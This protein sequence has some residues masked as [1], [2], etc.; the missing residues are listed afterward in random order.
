MSNTT[1]D[2]KF[3]GD[4]VEGS[5]RSA[6]VVA[7]IV[8]NLTPIRSVVD[9]GCGHATW[10]RAF[11]ELGVDDVLGLDGDYVDRSKIL[12]DPDQFPRST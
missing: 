2:E 9:F 5:L 3:Y 11:R 10:L 12:V 6:R 4:N 8:F 1:Y 7:P